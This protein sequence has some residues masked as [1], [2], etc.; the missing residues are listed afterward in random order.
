MLEEQAKI[1]KLLMLLDKLIDKQRIKVSQL[2]NRKQGL[3]QKM[4]V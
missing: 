1:S 2:K 3:L 4:F